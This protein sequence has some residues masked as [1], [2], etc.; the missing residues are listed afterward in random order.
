[1]KNKLKIKDS[2]M[3]IKFFKMSY[4]QS[5]VANNALAQIS[6]QISDDTIQLFTT[7]KKILD[8]LTAGFSNP[9]EKEKAKSTYR[10]L[11]QST[12]EF[13]FF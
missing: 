6:I 11:R 2:Y 8:M 13:N 3:L 4:I 9:N 1:M 10:S 12:R 7:A 5:L